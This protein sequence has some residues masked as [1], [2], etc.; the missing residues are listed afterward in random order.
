MRRSKYRNVRVVTS[1]G[2]KFDSKREWARYATL[3]WMQ[4]AGEIWDLKRQVKYR[5]EIAGI[6]I[7]DYVADFVYQT[8]AGQVV[9][10]SKGFRTPIY[11][12]KKKLMKAIHNIEV[13][14]S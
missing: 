11:R 10:D 13:Y 9:E 3:E 6:R 8:K 1:D 4:K 5:I 12:L 14:E 2:Q 7:C